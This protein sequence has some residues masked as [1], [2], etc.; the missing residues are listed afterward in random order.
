MTKTIITTLQRNNYQYVI[1]LVLET[2]KL[3]KTKQNRKGRGNLY[4]STVMPTGRDQKVNPLRPTRMT[5]TA[6]P[7]QANDPKHI[8]SPLGFENMFRQ[9]KFGY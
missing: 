6:T 2:K 1:Y 4:I 9:V 5:A 3:N 8:C 7:T